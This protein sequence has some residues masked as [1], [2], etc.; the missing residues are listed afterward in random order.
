[1][2][3]PDYDGGLRQNIENVVGDCFNELLEQ[4]TLRE[5]CMAY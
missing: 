1:M 5:E 2:G 3:G 4:F